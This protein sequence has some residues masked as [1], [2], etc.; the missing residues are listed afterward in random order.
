[1]EKNRWMA[2]K[3][4]CHLP[5]TKQAMDWKVPSINKAINFALSN[6]L[7]YSQSYILIDAITNGQ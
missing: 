6:A 4:A 3:G 7:N 5:L 2:A 1:M